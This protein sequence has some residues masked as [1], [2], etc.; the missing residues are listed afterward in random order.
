ML[1]KVTGTLST[2]Y[3]PVALT[4]IAISFGRSSCFSVSAVGKLICSSVYFEY[5]VLIMRKIRITIMTSISGTRLI[6]GSSLTR[7]GRKFIANL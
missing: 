2:T 4:S 3:C 6:S 7:P 1:E 5:V